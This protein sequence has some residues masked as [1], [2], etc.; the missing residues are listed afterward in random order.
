MSDLILAAHIGHNASACIGDRSGLRFAIQEERLR[1]EKNYWGFPERAI[2]VCLKAAGA[3]GKDVAQVAVGSNQV[4]SRYQSREDVVESYRRTQTLTG[5][6]RQRVA[7]PSMAALQ[8]NFERS[9]LGKAKFTHVDHHP[10]VRTPDEALHVFRQS[11]LEHLQAGS[12][13]VRNK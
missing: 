4:S 8:P 7:M 9:G 12:F 2:D 3:A 6:V 10:M 11:G 13:L 5:K 1:G